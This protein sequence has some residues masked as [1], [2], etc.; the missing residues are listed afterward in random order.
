MKL[1]VAALCA[2]LALIALPSRAESPSQAVHVTEAALKV[3]LAHP[4]TRTRVATDEEARFAAAEQG[5]TLPPGSYSAS[6]NLF[7]AD[8]PL[9]ETAEDGGNNEN[10]NALPARDWNHPWVIVKAA[11]GV[12]GNINAIV[13][14]YVGDT[15]TIE[16]GAGTGLA[17]HVFT[18][19]IRWRP[20]ATCWG[21]KGRNA[22]SV[23]FGLVGLG[24]TPN[25]T[26]WEGMIAAEA[27]AFY[28]HRFVEHF[29]LVVGLKT[30]VG[31]TIWM[32]NDQ[33]RVDPGLILQGYTG[34]AF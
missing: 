4:Q 2:M 27:D 30:G 16:V 12:P 17:A 21:C 29:G 33:P 23:G 10:K 22:F 3:L 26:R 18:G 19:A 11:I 20:E 6:S 24:A 15:I 7:P 14:V 32:L 9:R 28:M 31:P 5:I 34:L 25:Y 13:E 1:L 8:A